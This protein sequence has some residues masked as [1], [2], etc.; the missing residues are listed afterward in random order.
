MKKFEIT[1]H[2]GRLVGIRPIKTAT[3]LMAEGKTAAEIISYFT[4]KFE[5]TL[6]I[7]ELALTV[8]QTEKPIIDASDPKGVSL[9]I[10]IPFC[11]SRC[12]YCSFSS[13]Q[14]SHATHL[15][16]E[17]LQA[18][19]KELDAALFIINRN[20]NIVE[21]IYIGGGTPTVLDAAQLDAL[22]SKLSHIKAKEFTVEAGRP[23]TITREKLEILKRH[24]VTRISI[25]PQTMDD[26]TLVRIGRKHTSE[27]TRAAIA[28]AR[29]C[30]FDNINMDMIA[31]LPGETFD[32][33]RRTLEEICA[34]SPENITV[35]A[36][37]VKRTSD[38][39]FDLRGK[40]GAI[41]GTNPSITSNPNIESDE[42]SADLTRGDEVA[43]MVKFSRETLTERGYTPYYLYRQKHTLGDCENVG[44]SKPGF[45]GIYN[46]HMMSEIQT[47][48]AIGA[49][50]VT[51]FV[52]SR[53]S[54]IERIFNVKEAIDYINR[55]DEMIER[56]N[57]LIEISG[58]L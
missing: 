20:K 54:N 36:M 9:Y 27:Q 31:G 1:K 55:I 10:H 4:D 40:A 57:L 3:R 2:W 49:G 32:T 44:Y 56:K 42:N 19:H 47:I 37:C 52:D 12:F 29:K 41:R 51:K 39:N 5:T 23:D 38:L 21:T 46:I 18:L 15:I 58:N 17:Y 26:E 25:N 53:N 6:E 11:P 28:E 33:F 8:A 16:P 45:E 43:R 50:S 22:L 7:A 13:P 30:G 34:L 48:I 14:S 35:H 24:N